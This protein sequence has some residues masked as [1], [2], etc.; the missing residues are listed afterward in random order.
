M[1]AQLFGM[2]PFA[3]DQLTVLEGDLSKLHDPDE[4]YIAAVYGEDDYGNP[5]MGSRNRAR[6]GDTVTLRYVDEI[7]YYYT[8]TGEIIADFR[9]WTEMGPETLIPVW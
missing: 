5:E 8:D 2:E 6:L 1:N 9:R 4:R 3:L 7:E